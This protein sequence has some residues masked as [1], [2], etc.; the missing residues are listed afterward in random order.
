MEGAKDPDEYV[1]KYGTGRF[2]MLVENAI[3]LVEFKIKVLKKELDINNVNDKIKFLNEIS[4]I[5][6]TVDN[7]IEKEVYIDK[8]A[9]EYNISKEAIYAQINKLT[10][11]QNQGKKVLERNFSVKPKIKNEQITETLIKRENMI[12]ALLINEGQDVYNQIKDSIIPEDFK[13]Q[14]N[15]E[16]I[17]KMYEEYEKG[18]SNTS[19]ILD[20][21]EG[22]EQIISYITGI[23]ATDYGITDVKKSI[24]DIIHIYKKEKLTSKKNEIMQKLDDENLKQEDKV[25]LEKQLTN[26]I[27]ELAKFK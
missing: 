26:V 7:N 5:L 6:S 4:K 14:E 10:Y 24:K 12:I 18:N 21:F 17:T 3:S 19:N 27:I 2:N 8:I 22:N 11:S 15:K 25:D 20:L 13:K 16:I 9:S 23:M 1:I